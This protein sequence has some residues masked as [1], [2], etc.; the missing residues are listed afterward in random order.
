MGCPVV[1]WQILSRNPEAT[2]EFYASLFGWRIDADNALAYRAVDTC[3]ESG[4]GG[5]IWPAPP[6]AH[7]FVQLF[8]EVE[9]VAATV[10]EATARG[11]RVVVPPQKLPDGDEMAILLDPQ[12]MSFGVMRSARD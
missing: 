5:G 4:V 12:G 2:A 8:A 7:N 6:E 11:A 1:S 10:K 3:S 9:D